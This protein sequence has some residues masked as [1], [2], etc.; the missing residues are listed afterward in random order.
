M[1]SDRESAVYEFRAARGVRV[2]GA[3]W[4]DLIAAFVRTLVDGERAWTV[5]D[6]LQADALAL[7][8]D[9]DEN[10]YVRG[11]R[12]EHGDADEYREWMVDRAGLDAATIDEEIRNEIHNVLNPRRAYRWR[13]RKYSQRG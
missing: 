6:L 8:F 9:E 5:D 12:V 1:M 11:R 13:V 3:T 10:L 7:S 2:T 4:D